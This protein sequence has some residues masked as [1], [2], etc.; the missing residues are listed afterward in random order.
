MKL[1]GRRREERPRSDPALQPDV[2][3]TGPT[4]ATTS[5]AVTD[6]WEHREHRPGCHVP[7]VTVG[8]SHLRGS[9]YSCVAGDSMPKQS[10][11]STQGPRLAWT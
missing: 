11:I 5:R 10:Q 3:K 6:T 9:D 4:V 8:V 2:G 7:S 1:T